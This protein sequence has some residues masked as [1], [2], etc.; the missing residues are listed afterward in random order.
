MPRRQAIRLA[1]R[2]L[3]LSRAERW[4]PAARD[5]AGI[6]L[7]LHHVAPAAP[8]AFAPNAHLSVTPEFLDS[9]IAH[10]KGRGW[11]FVSVTDLLARPEGDARRAALTL[12]DGFRD[13]FEHAWP[14]F[15]RHA[16]PFTIFVCPGFCDR[17]AELWW[18]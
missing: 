4:L 18:E 17:T 14:V 15:R 13:N 10:L 7:T 12:D 8:A 5:A 16:V 9:S 11:R 2:A 1:L 6:V 3:S